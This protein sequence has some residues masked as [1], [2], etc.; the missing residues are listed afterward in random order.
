M[1]LRAWCVEGEQ[2][3]LKEEFRPEM[4]FGAANTFLFTNRSD[5]DLLAPVLRSPHTQ[6]PHAAV[7][8]HYLLINPWL[9]EILHLFLFKDTSTTQDY[10]LSY[11]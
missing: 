3:E 4:R 10:V 2:L 6:L 1:I 11:L 7:D 8:N 5:A 9:L